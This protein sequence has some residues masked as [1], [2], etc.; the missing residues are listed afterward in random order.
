M[1]TKVKAIKCPKC[2]DTIY[3]VARHDCHHCSCGDV[4]VDGGFDYLRFGWQAGTKPPK[5]FELTINATKIALYNDWNLNL[6][7]PRK[8]GLIKANKVKINL[9]L[10][11]LDYFKFEKIFK[12][13]KVTNIKLFF[14]VVLIVFILALW[15][16]VYVARADWIILHENVTPEQ[17]EQSLQLYLERIAK[18]WSFIFD[19]IKRDHQLNIEVAKFRN[20]IALRQAGINNIYVNA[21]GFG[22]SIVNTNTTTSEIG[23]TSSTSR[24]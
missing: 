14:R 11:V 8:F 22:G 15:F 1:P 7:T 13:K 24:N 17:E 6:R 2:K 21:R 12:V 9:K 3:S 18:R 20:E 5:P 10:K 4:M 19:E 16:L 23:N